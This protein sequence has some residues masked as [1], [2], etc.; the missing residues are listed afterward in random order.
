MVHKPAGFGGDHERGAEGY[1]TL[2]VGSGMGHG[3]TAEGWGAYSASPGAG[4]WR[5]GQG[6]PLLVLAG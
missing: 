5:S 4:H 1:G 6:D 3:S 2:L